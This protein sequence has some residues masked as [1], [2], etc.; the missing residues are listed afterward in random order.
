[1][2]KIK[3]AYERPSKDDGYRVLVDRVWPRGQTKQ[4]LALNEWAKALAPSTALRKLFAHDPQRW[5][6]FQTRYRKELKS[7]AEAV[8][9]LRTLKRLARRR[10]VTLVYGAHD[11]R[12][13]QA[14]VLRKLI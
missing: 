12:Y 7:N 3:R 13:N 5:A 4:Q 14:V 1:M 9:K 8:E 10:L 6:I 11:Q 2:V